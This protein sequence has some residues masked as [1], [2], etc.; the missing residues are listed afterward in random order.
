MG[1]DGLLMLL[2]PLATKMH[3]SQFKGQ[4]LG[5]DI[6]PWLYKGCYSNVMHMSE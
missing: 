5:V 3:I 6:L 4:T 2:K 1:I